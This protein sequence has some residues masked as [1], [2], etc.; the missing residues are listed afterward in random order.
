M[1][2]A[3]ASSFAVLCCEQAL[4][5]EGSVRVA[6]TV[7]ACGIQVPVA[8]DCAACVGSQ[9]CAQARDCAGDPACLALETCLLGCARDYACRS[10]C[11]TA[12]PGQG[13][14][15]IPALDTCVAA[16][17]NDSCGLI[18][19]VPGSY[20]T[21]DVAQDCQECIEFSGCG[22]TEACTHD[23]A[24]ETAAE[25][26]YACTTPDCRAACAADAGATSVVAT[27]LDAAFT[28]GPDCYFRCKWGQNWTCVGK[29]GPPKA[30][31]QGLPQSVA[32]SL[33]DNGSGVAG[34]SVQACGANDDACANPL[35]GGTSDAQG[36]LTLEGLPPAGLYGFEGF[37]LLQSP[38]I[39]KTMSFLSFPL[40]VE[41]AQLQL[42]LLGSTELT[43]DLADVAVNADPNRGHILVFVQDCLQLPAPDVTVSAVGLND[44]GAQAVY[45]SGLKPTTTLTSTTATGAMMFVDMKPGQWMLE[46][47]PTKT[48]Q[49]A[50]HATVYVGAGMLS[51]VTMM[52]ASN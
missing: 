29:A 8:G 45:F 2:C 6:Q 38:A 9:C 41:H 40:S 28:V 37:F 10:N 24:C 20:T 31:A 22:A 50:S 52:P 1:V 11:I 25:C 35:A 36:N 21:P 23:L 43:Q 34:V 19:G 3:A 12:Y 14:L 32:L 51:I 49:V 5:I 39:P 13:Q 26:G 47:T 18:C 4:S 15:D 44:P 46:A 27:F 7:N 33:S 42:L 17:C 16:S 30:Q 48:G